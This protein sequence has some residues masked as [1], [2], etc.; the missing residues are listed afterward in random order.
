[1]GDKTH[2]RRMEA[3]VDSETLGRAFA[4]LSALEF[5]RTGRLPLVAARQWKWSW[6]REA[7]RRFQAGRS[8]VSEV[9]W[10]KLYWTLEDSSLRALFCALTLGRPEKGW[11]PPEP[12]R[13]LFTNPGRPLYSLISRFGRFILRS[14]PEDEGHDFVY[15]GDDTL[16]LMERSRDLLKLLLGSGVEQ[17]CCLDLC[18]GGGGVGLALPPFEG[19]LL[20]V[21]LNSHAIELA[22]T[23]AQAQ[24]LVNYRYRCM[25]TSEGLEGRF[26]LVF[27]NPPTL[28]SQLTGSDVFH[29]TGT[30][31]QFEALLDSV[32]GA[33]HP[34][35]RAVFTLFSQRTEGHD[36]AFSALEKRLKGERG[37]L[38]SV[39]R[40]FPLKG[41]T[42]LCHCALELLP[43]GEIAAHYIPLK[44]PAF[45]LGGLSWRR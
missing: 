24:N 29:A 14:H 37:F 17:P 36:P 31:T 6:E 22:R 19:E 32:L 5:H 2:S 28:S 18:C 33:L 44:G 10:P 7:W 12:L 20:G 4:Y 13:F 26:H 11:E 21:D 16:Y 45:R 30:W 15:F 35:G 25:D 42:E 34:R 39:R 27:G 3:G 9:A 23:T 43:R 8:N 38:Y 41:G 1:M 40:V